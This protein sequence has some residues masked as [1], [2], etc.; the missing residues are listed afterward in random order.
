[1]NE[2]CLLYFIDGKPYTYEHNLNNHN[3]KHTHVYIWRGEEREEKKE[4]W[5]DIISRDGKERKVIT[6][7]S[8]EMISCPGITKKRRSEERKEKEKKSIEVGPNRDTLQYEP[9]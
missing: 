2:V 5:D 9:F 1:M 4:K 7:I 3:W 6:M 8:L